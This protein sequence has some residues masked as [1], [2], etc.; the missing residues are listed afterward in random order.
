MQLGR[1]VI[2]D[3]FDATRNKGG[4]FSPYKVDL[5]S[6][7]L[8][9]T[10]FEWGCMFTFHVIPGISLCG[11]MQ[12]RRG[13]ESLALLTMITLAYDSARYLLSAAC[14]SLLVRHA[15]QMVIH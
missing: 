7:L 14:F 3:S 2:G 1:V 10:R 4:F 8:S 12:S 13:R 5:L 15:F 9:M 6:R 11:F